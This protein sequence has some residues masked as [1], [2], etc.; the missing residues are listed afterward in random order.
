MQTPKAFPPKDEVDSGHWIYEP[1]PRDEDLPI[2]ENVFLHY[3]NCNERP[4]NII[5]LK[6]MP[7]KLKT[8]ITDD[9]PAPVAFGWGVHI[10]EGPNYY[11]IAWGNV[12]ALVI[13]GIVA[14]IWSIYKGDFQG[15]F[16][17]ASWLVMVVNTFMVAFI[18]RYKQI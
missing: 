18:Y 1:C 7:R 5:W 15:A 10:D 8:K 12:I 13:S 14:I 16:G 3:M 6:R 2:A 17:F 11:I 4:D 9:K